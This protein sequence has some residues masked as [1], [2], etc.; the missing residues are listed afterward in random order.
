M[1]TSVKG[2]Y[3]IAV[4]EGIVPAPYL[5]PAGYFTFGIGHAETSGLPPNPRHMP[6]GMPANVDG[7]IREAFDLFR[8]RI[9]EYEK[10]VNRAVKVPLAQHEFDALV[11][12]HFNT[13]RIGTASAIDVLNAGGDRYEVVR[14]LKFFNKA[15]GRR[16]IGLVRR[17]EDEGRMFLNAEYPPD[18]IPVY[19]VTP[20]HKVGRVISRIHREEALRLLRGSEPPS[21]AIPRPK[22]PKLPAGKQGG[23]IAAIVAAVVALIV[24]RG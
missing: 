15:G 18:P 1:K 5:D 6:K 14:R 7:A 10:G 24:L 12:F 19:A 17:R 22:L 16:M 21:S 2:L 4:H 9:T 20:D 8:K 23:I 11:S 13:G 3:A